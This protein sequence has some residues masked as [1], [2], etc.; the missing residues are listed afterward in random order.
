MRSGPGSRAAYAVAVAAAL[1]LA[2]CA[3]TSGPPVTKLVGDRVVVTRAISPEAYEHVARALLYEGEERWEEAADELQRALSLDADAAEVRAE[4]GELFVRL[5]RLDDADEQIDRSLSTAASVQGYLARA[6]LAEAR[7]DGARQREALRSALNEALDGDD[8]EAIERTDLEL[9]DAQVVALDLPAALETLR[10]LESAVPDTLRG[11]TQ[12]AAVAWALGRLEESEAALHGALQR[13]PADV[14][15][16]VLLGELEAAEGRAPEAKTTFAEAVERADV[17]L[18][19]ADGVAGWLVQRGE[20][21]EATELAERTIANVGDADGLVLASALE[22]TVKRPERAL[23]LAERAATLGAAGTRVELLRAE[24]LVDKGE[25]ARGV[26]L[27]LGIADD[28]PEYL[29]ARV[30][31]A[32]VL[33]DDRKLDEADQALET[34]LRKTDAA[35]P[36][37]ERAATIAIAR[38]QLDEKRGDAVRAARRL[39]E[40]LAADAKDARLVLARAAVDDRRG[41]WRQG[42]A[43]AEKLLAREPRNVEALNFAGFLAADHGQ[44]LPLATKRLQA[45]VALSPGSG[46]IVDSLGWVYFRAG[47]LARAAT[48]LEQASRLEPDDPEILEHV[49]D[50]YAKRGERAKALDAYRRAQGGKPSDAVARDLAERVRT[51]EAKSA[52]GR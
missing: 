7:H 13:E 23:A 33:R 34:A 20:L 50:L 16:R 39:D 30:R 45:A 8:P 19:I 46:G 38:S 51:L 21:A 14:D 18:Q 22:R 12:H 10:A 36:D 32:E 5:D 24:A 25:H 37:H 52:A 4:L 49:G 2:G 47:D 41:E 26:K 28:A 48:F 29:E 40:A 3:T 31:A 11:R 15:A 42:L 6:H 1:A 17:P 27:L 9:A 44:D 35:K 43:L